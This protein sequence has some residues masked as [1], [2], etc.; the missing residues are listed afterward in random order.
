MEMEDFKRPDHND[1]ATSSELRDRSFSGVRNNEL[2]QTREIWIE[3]N[4]AASMSIMEIG[5]RP[6]SWEQL[7]RDVFRLT[8]AK[9]LEGKGH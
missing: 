5:F 1:F 8:N 7:Y 9:T 3:G 4:L 2:L 6:E